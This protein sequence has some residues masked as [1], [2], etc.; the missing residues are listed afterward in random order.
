LVSQDSTGLVRTHEAALRNA[1]FVL[2]NITI[3][4]GRDDSAAFGTARAS[5]AKKLTAES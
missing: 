1:A 4:V 5:A 2:L 3:F